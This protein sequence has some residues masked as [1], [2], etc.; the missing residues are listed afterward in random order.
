MEFIDVR[1]VTFLELTSTYLED[2]GGTY[3]N[4]WELRNLGR[5]NEQFGNWINAQISVSEIG[6]I[7]MPYH[8]HIRNGRTEIVVPQKGAPLSEVYNF[9]RDNEDEFKRENPHCYGRIIAQRDR[10]LSEKAKS[11]F[12]SEEPLHLDEGCY[13]GLTGFR[14]KIT[15]LDGFHRFMGLMHIKN[16]EKPQFVD[17]YIAIYDFPKYLKN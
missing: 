16:E 11:I 17:S 2:H 14:G 5:A 8:P 3:R 15:H 9:L 12:L 6:E 4:E 10:L 1:P 7:I 13:S